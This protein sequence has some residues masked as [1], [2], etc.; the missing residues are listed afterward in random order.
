MIGTRL[1]P[2]LEEIEMTILEHEVRSGTPPQYTEAGFRAAT[3]IFMSA[4]LDKMWEL[5]K[6]E[7]IPM[8]SRAAMATK[9]GES[10]RELINIYTG[11]DTFELYKK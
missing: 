2:V 1:S 11:I 5:Q 7:D 10:I 6:H 4:V 3:K 8:E 9:A